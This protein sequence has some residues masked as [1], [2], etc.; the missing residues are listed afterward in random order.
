V[1]DDSVRY[2]ISFDLDGDELD[3]REEVSSELIDLCDLDLVRVCELAEC[4]EYWGGEVLVIGEIRWREIKQTFS[5]SLIPFF[6]FSPCEESC[7]PK[8][9]VK[10]EEPSVIRSSYFI[11][12]HPVPFHQKGR[13]G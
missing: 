2:A 9:P 4:S 6:S 11:P 7:L 3:S 13:E 5:F 1:D 12:T 10:R 8:K